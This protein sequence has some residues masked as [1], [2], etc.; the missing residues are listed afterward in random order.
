M[1]QT[2]REIESI[3]NQA[4]I[5]PLKRFGQ[6]FLIDG[7][8]IRKLV[9]AA[10]I[11]PDD[12]VVEVGP[13]TGTLTEELLSTAG[14]VIAVEIDK[15]LTAVLHER[16]KNADNFTLLHTDVLERKSQIAPVVL[17]TLRA[18]RSELGG[19]AMLVANLPYQAATPLLVDLLLGDDL[20]SPLCFTVQ[21]EMADRMTASE[22]SSEYGP[23][24]IYAQTLAT[25][26]R[27]ARI[28][29]QAFW[30]AP[31]VNS[32]MLRLDVKTGPPVPPELKRTLAKLVH[33]CFLHRRK[34]LRWNL[35]VLLDAPA[36]D[37]VAGD[38]RW[39]LDDRPEQ[40]TIDQWVAL[41]EFLVARPDPR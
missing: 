8:L 41:A 34:T 17:D 32:A 40:L 15:G 16:F 23:L 13:G 24:A 7:N 38:G 10:E 39:S 11:R 27:I 1:V 20:V 31:D 2:R 6:N 21:A 18:K 33:A 30:P 37:R 25:P 4:G 29:P 19:R 14:H 35:R 28:P 12:T 5:R 36:L 9:K 3:L 22:G 26:T